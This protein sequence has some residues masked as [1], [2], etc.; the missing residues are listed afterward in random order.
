MG[1]SVLIVL[2]EFVSSST[3]DK[4]SDWSNK[5]V[6]NYRVKTELITKEMEYNRVYPSMPS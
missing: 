6:L 2:L 1:K 4:P 3:A 5:A